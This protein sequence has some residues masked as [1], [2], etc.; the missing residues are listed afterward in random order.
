MKKIISAL[1]TVIAALC[2]CVPAFAG[3]TT[4]ATEKIDTLKKGSIALTYKKGDIK[5]SDKDISIYKVADVN[6][7]M[8]YTVSSA[9][10]SK[11]IDFTALNTADY[12][13]LSDTFFGYVNADKVS[14]VASKKTDAEGKVSFAGLS[15]GLYLV[16]P[17]TSQVEDTVYSFKPLM[18]AVPDITGNGTWNYDVSVNP[19]SM[20]PDK[21]E[22]KIIVNWDDGGN[23]KERP[24]ELK[25][26]IFKDGKL[27]ETVTLNKDNNWSYNWLSE[28]IASDWSVAVKGNSAKYTYAV[29]LKD[30]VFTVNAKFIPS[31]K[32]G[33]EFNLSLIIAVMALSLSF[34]VVSLKKVKN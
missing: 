19:K 23:E 33:E 14:A 6:A 31:P 2:L 26:D 11:P 1:L 17:L 21:K 28:D 13:A 22:R 12:G 5:F 20:L 30:N 9:F 29:N 32:T 18:I 3:S 27:V 15:V 4:T 24:E 8:V 10:A 25:V 34:A 7:D 16:S